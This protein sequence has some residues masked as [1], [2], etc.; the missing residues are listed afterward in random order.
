[1]SQSTF[2]AKQD[3]QDEYKGGETGN[4]IYNPLQ[5]RPVLLISALSVWSTFMGRIQ[6][7][8]STFE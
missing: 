1:M 8:P 4:S 6:A 7:R 2:E 3:E 5:T